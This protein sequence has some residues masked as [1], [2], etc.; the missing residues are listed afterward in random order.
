MCCHILPPQDSS[1]DS[2][3]YDPDAEVAPDD[4]DVIHSSEEEGD[5]GPSSTKKPRLD[6]NPPPDSSDSD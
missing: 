6:P 2:A 3:D 4:D 5:E 1:G